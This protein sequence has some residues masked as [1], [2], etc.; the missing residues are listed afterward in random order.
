MSATDPRAALPP[1]WTAPGPD[2]VLRASALAVLL[3]LGAAALAG[4]EPARLAAWLPP[5]PF[6]AVT[7]VP[8]PGC[9]IT[10]ALL[11]L[12][13]LRVGEAL[14]LH[15]FAPLVVGLAALVAVRPAALQRTRPA[16][17]GLA[18]AGLLALWVMRLATGAPV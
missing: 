1:R 12:A 18:L 17:A 3:A 6:R 14:A 13:Q 4:L 15:P 10:R 7:G 8:C 2:A 9:G 16:W 11:A 5:C